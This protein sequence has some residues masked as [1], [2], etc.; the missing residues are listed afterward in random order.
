MG[1]NRSTKQEIGAGPFQEQRH[2]LRRCPRGTL[3]LWMTC[4][5]DSR[6]VRHSNPYGIAQKLT[7]KATSFP[8]LS[9]EESSSLPTT[10]ASAVHHT[11]SSNSTSLSQRHG[12]RAR[13]ALPAPTLSIRPH[14]P[15]GRSPLPEIA[16]S[17]TASVPHPFRTGGNI[18][19][20]TDTFEYRC[21]FTTPSLHFF[22]VSLE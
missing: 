5:G 16:S 1:E 17:S 14:P 7:H 9:F 10:R 20:L 13:L 15:H 22:F 8:Q 2:F 12:V 21:K 11:P 6:L 19:L 18:Q 4:C 3:R